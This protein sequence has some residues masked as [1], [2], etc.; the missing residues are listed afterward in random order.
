MTA[1]LALVSEL[2]K[3][4]PAA[5]FPVLS[6]P[7]AAAEPVKS[8]PSTVKEV[9][10]NDPRK[11]PPP[12][13]PPPKPPPPPLELIAG[14][15]PVI[16]VSVRVRPPAAAATLLSLATEDRL[17]DVSEPRPTLRNV[18]TSMLVPAAGR[19]LVPNA[20]RNPKLP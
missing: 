18:S 6:G 17:A 8:T 19:L 9:G 14:I 1:T 11:L 13:P 16:L 3:D 4:R 15:L 2:A 12:P 7:S 20:P 5:S 10:V